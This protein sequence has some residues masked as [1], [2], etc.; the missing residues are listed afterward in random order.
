M[1]R[2]LHIVSSC[3]DGKRGSIA[4]SLR[5]GSYRQT[6]IDARFRAWW[7][8]L[9]N[10]DG[11][12]RSPVAASELYLGDHWAV[13]RDL[14]A[15]AHQQGMV[16]RLWVLS[17]GYGLLPADT[18]L[19]PYA[20]TFQ[21]RHEDSV[22]RAT[23]IAQISEQRAWWK[24]LAS[25][26]CWNGETPRSIS[27]LAQR[28]PEGIILLI[29]S[30]SYLLAVEDDLREA[31][32]Q[33]SN[34]G[35]LVIVSSAA[36]G[37]NPALEKRRVASNAQLRK[38]VH[39]SLLSLHARV[40]RWLIQTEAEHSFELH[41]IQTMVAKASRKLPAPTKY[42]RKPSTDE[43]V[44]RFMRDRLYS[45][46]RGSHTRLLREWRN[47]GRA[48]EQSRFRSLFFELQEQMR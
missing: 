46:P 37:L 12:S 3:S 11:P 19:F 2:I 36:R 20:A 29:A 21:P 17:A 15:L 1:Q 38:L 45:D 18:P 31:L 25:Q 47:S 9:T 26:P 40:A 14:P 6:G 22:S 8:T 13:S 32:P 23:G 42:D 5:M 24:L 10:A 16:A 27:G 41:A 33:F 48:C 43:E 7:S 39:G 4:A 28:S 44:R 30:P 34:G 35:G